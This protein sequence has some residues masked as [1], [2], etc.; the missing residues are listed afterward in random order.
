MIIN[1]E[2]QVRAGEV[3]W[4]DVVKLTY[5]TGQLKESEMKRM[6]QNLQHTKGM[7]STMASLYTRA[8]RLPATEY[9][10]LMEQMNPSE[11]TALL[12][13]TQQVMKKY[14]S[15]AMKSMTPQERSQD[16][17]LQRILNMMHP[18]GNQVSYA[19][20]PTSPVIPEPV[21]NEVAY[22]YTAT[23]PQT[24]HKVGSNN[25]TDWFDHQTGE[26]ING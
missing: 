19:P 20:P 25:G 22:L 2:D 24:G 15:K 13:L 26:P 18:G 12:P 21:K 14:T 8:S 5:N 6:Q 4:P 16:P 10:Q 11:K 1:L 7:D 9:L 23:H 3:S 17:T